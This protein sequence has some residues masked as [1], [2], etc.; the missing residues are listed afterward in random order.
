M[1]SFKR[2]LI[3]ESENLRKY[4]STDQFGVYKHAVL[5]EFP[6]LSRKYPY[7]GG[8]L[9]RGLNFRT[10][11]EYLEFRRAVRTGVL[12]AN[13]ITSWSPSQS[14][15]KSFAVAPQVFNVTASILSGYDPDERV[16]G[17][18]GVI[19]V[20]K[21][22]SG[23]GIDVRK[24]KVGVEDEVILPPGNY[25]I[26]DMI[27]EK[28][29]RHLVKKLDINQ[30]VVEIVNS[31]KNIDPDLMRALFKYKGGDLYDD[32]KTL[33]VKHA[34]DT[35]LKTK[36]IGLVEG[37]HSEFDLYRRE[38]EYGLLFPDGKYRF[39]ITGSL[40]LLD[41]TYFGSIREYISMSDM[42][43]IQHKLIDDI[44]KATKVIAGKKSLIE[45]EHGFRYISEVFDIRLSQ[46]K[47]LSQSY[48]S[49]YHRFNELVR[50]YNR[51]KHFD[52]RVMIE[53]LKTSME[54]PFK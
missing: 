29:W 51:Q 4:T 28:K 12:T 30:E 2:Y 33:I 41:H 19:L 45:Y 1:I 39:Y 47:Y 14:T 16:M 37:K 17:F 48:G 9:Y 44:N 46:L 54:G 3:A 49:T 35:F 6:V 13:H 22:K 42:N 25:Q 43:R 11:R 23:V 20:I 8:T 5:D 34:V 53:L 32:T 21:V 15:A 27:P 18:I 52:M 36:K 10:P 26:V 31:K 7:D 50:D 40:G 38:N 24:S